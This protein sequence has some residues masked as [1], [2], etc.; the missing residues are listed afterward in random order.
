MPTPCSATRATT[1]SRAAPGDDL[2]DGGAGADRLQG[3]P[4][5][6]VLVSRDAA[7]DELRCG[8]GMRSRGDRRRR[9]GRR[10]ARRSVRAGG[11]R[12]ARG[13]DPRARN[14]GVP[15]AVP[16][17]GHARAPSGSRPRGR[18]VAYTGADR[19]LRR[20]RSS[21]PA[22]LRRARVRGAAFSIE[23]GRRGARLTLAPRGPVSCARPRR[24]DVTAAGRLL[25]DARRADVL[26][27]NAAWTV[28][29]RCNG[30][31]VAVRRGRVRL[32]GGRA[33]RAPAAVTVRGRR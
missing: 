14:A 16:P 27:S 21:R 18:A 24:L 32:A 4:G 9:R 10:H 11:H 28:S 20:N 3:G 31:R 12:R 19:A 2:I 1:C 25:V 6:D 22:S 15:G 26:G 33:L 8:P 13:A 23:R 30:T 29:E 5:R 17:A 7:L